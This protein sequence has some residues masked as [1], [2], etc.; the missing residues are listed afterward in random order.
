MI[1][2]EGFLKYLVE[3]TMGILHSELFMFYKTSKSASEI[4][5]VEFE[6]LYR[7]LKLRRIFPRLTS[8]PEYAEHNSF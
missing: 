3:M 8:E 6:F 5:I 1:G 4:S 7:G 2:S